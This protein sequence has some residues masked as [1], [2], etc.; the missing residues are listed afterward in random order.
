[1]ATTVTAGTLYRRLCPTTAEFSSVLCCC[2]GLLTRNVGACASF[3]VPQVGWD[4]E[5]AL[6][7]H[8]AQ[9]G[10]KAGLQVTHYTWLGDT[11]QVQSMRHPAP[12]SNH[13]RARVSLVTQAGTRATRVMDVG[14][15]ESLERC[16]QAGCIALRPCAQ[17]PLRQLLTRRTHHIPCKPWSPASE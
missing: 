1:M 6:L 9:G 11:C 3:T 15:H 2:F 4:L 10:H 5:L 7:T 16:T 17:L 12:T 8:T 13:P 14:A